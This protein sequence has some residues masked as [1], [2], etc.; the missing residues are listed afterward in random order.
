MKI[1]ERRFLTSTTNS[2][3]A[4]SIE[5]F[6]GKPVFA[7]FGGMREGFPDSSIYI[8]GLDEQYCFNIG[9]EPQWNPILV[10][11]SDYEGD[12]DEEK[13]ILF[14][15]VG[16]FC[17]RWSTI[18]NDISDLDSKKNFSDYSVLPAGLNGPVKTRPVNYSGNWFFGASVENF[19]NWTSY[20]ERYEIK[21][22]DDF[23]NNPGSCLVESFLIPS[24]MPH[25][26]YQT[27][28]SAKGLIQPSLWQDDKGVINAFMRSD[29][30]FIYHWKNF[31]MCALPTKF[32]NPNSGVDTVYD[33][34][35]LYLV[36]NPSKESRIPLL[37]D[38][39]DEDFNVVES[40]VV[41]D[42][43]IDEALT[44]EL[45]YPYMIEKDGFLHLVYTNGRKKI[46]YVV[47][48]LEK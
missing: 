43:V 41:A 24:S 6:K 28:P 30:G 34:G 18:I 7:W 39:L 45:S 23:I 27:K 21:L 22:V 20:L 37:V 33:D 25:E 10:N 44:Q 26:K 29:L 31:E 3:H 15:K 16:K 13:L 5:F 48:D 9:N 42:S 8:D 2:V 38:K 12:S 36:Y 1:I 47:I 40:L 14:S 19:M 32:E 4:A 17:D 11:M 35:S 46:E